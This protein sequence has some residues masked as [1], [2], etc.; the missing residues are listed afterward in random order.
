MDEGA[1]GLILESQGPCF[2]GSVDYPLP[3]R[4]R[5]VG[6]INLYFDARM[7]VSNPRWRDS[8]VSLFEEV[9]R[10]LG[11][12]YGRGYVRRNMWVHGRA[13]ASD[14]TSEILPSGFQGWTW[15]GIP[16]GAPTWLTWFGRPYMDLVARAVSTQESRRFP[17]GVSLRLDREPKDRDQLRGAFPPLPPDL[18]S[19]V[20]K[21]PPPRDPKVTPA[22]VIPPLS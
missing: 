18:L 19:S 1:G 8:V 15:I 4:P 16:S 12:F 7:L 21:Q 9:A 11:A 17:E 14:G 10:R 13:V 22:E 6:E 5:A 20:E 2:G 3:E